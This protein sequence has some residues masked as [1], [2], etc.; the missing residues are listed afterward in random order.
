M[1]CKNYIAIL[2]AYFERGWTTP[3]IGSISKLAT[4]PGA[5]REASSKEKD[6]GVSS[7]FKTFTTS[8]AVYPEKNDERNNI[9]VVFV[10][11]HS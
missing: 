8:R 9:I 1:S 6:I 11:S 5:W 4:W 2:Q 7:S 10:I 3:F